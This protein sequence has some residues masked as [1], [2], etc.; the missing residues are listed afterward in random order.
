MMFGSAQIPIL[1]KAFVESFAGVYLLYFTCFHLIAG[2]T[3]S[4]FVGFDAE[5]F[6]AAV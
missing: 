5:C 2:R 1:R 6:N 4:L 3:L